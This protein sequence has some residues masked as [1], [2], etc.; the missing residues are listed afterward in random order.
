MNAP[1]GRRALG[2]CLA[3]VTLVAWACASRSSTAPGPAELE[4][5]ALRRLVPH[6]EVVTLRPQAGTVRLDPSQ[7]LTIDDLRGRQLDPR[8]PRLAPRPAPFSGRLGDAAGD[9]APHIAPGIAPFR[10][11]YFDC[12][13]HYDGTTT[14]PWPAYEYA[15]THGF[16]RLGAYSLQ[17]TNWPHLPRPTEWV[18]LSG[19]N[20][21]GWFKQH[22]IDGRRWDKL[23]EA[24]SRGEALFKP[25]HFAVKPGYAMIM[26]DQEYGGLLPVAELRRQPWYPAT[27]D[28]ETRAAFEDRYFLG[29][30]IGYTEPGEAARRDGWARTSIY[31]WQPFLQ[32][33]YNLDPRI[34]LDFSVPWAKRFIDRIYDTYDILH[35][36]GYC[37]EWSAGNVAYTLAATDDAVAYAR[38]RARRKPVRMYLA[39]SILSGPPGSTFWL[40]TQ[41][42]PNEEVR[43]MVAL[44]FFTG[45]DGLV[46]WNYADGENHQ[47]PATPRVPDPTKIWSRLLLQ[48]GNPFAAPRADDP[49]SVL[50]FQRYDLLRVTATNATGQVRFGRVDPARPDRAPAADTVGELAATRLTRQ[51][52]PTV[53]PV[54]AMVEG[55][56]LVRPLEYVLR[57]GEP[58]IDVP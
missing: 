45:A 24:K 38:T 12:E 29:Y 6:F 41:P 46:Q 44:Q 22:G 10:F 1:V 32:S 20:W 55:L 36:D 28:A 58:V 35:I 11:R 31:A 48:V 8:P 17:P 37:T 40:H 56:A 19:C 43:A 7:S 26:I 42:L 51:L 21:T 16:N 4:L 25:G 53:E 57:H 15:A 52:R 2:F 39:T 27:A 30:T 47:V 33:W 14:H 23:A 3:A 54:A 49:N 13:Y 5:R 18:L 50:R 34:K 9:P